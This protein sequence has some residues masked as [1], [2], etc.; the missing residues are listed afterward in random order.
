VRYRSPRP[1][2]AADAVDEFACESGEQTAWLIR[3]AKQSAAANITKVF[4]V[5]EEGSDVVVAFYAW[6]MAQVSLAI[7]PKRLAQ[8]TSRYPQPV[9]LLARLGV[10][11]KHEGRGLGAGLLRDAV[12]RLVLVG[13]QIGCRGLLIH[14]ESERARSFYLHLI[15]EL[16]ESPTD[17]LHLVLLLKDAERSLRGPNGRA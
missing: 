16:I 17:R 3:H 15:P 9:A 8:G 13:D 1:I 7:A 4:V 11:S 2:D 10:D 14:A 6:T 12:V 5:T